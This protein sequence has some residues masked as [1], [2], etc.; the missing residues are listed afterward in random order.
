MPTWQEV[1]D[2]LEALAASAEAEPEAVA[3]AL[4]IPAPD[5]PLP[6]HLALRARAVLARLDEAERVLLERR[7]AVRRQLA[8]RR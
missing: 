7:D 2:T 8:R 3:G 1:L 6:D 4:E 5:G